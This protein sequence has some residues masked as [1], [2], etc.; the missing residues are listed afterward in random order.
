M[1]DFVNGHHHHVVE[2]AGDG[3]G[4][5]PDE[6]PWGGGEEPAHCGLEGE[7]SEDDVLCARARAH[8]ALDLGVSLEDGGAAD[9]VGL[10]GIVPVK[11]VLCA[12]HW[13]KWG[14]G[15]CRLCAFCEAL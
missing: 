6:P 12:G 7:G 5:E 13:G 3:V 4:A 1:G 10:V 8:E 14:G 9:G 2:G 11:I 15:V